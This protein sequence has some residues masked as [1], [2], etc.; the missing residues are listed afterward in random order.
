MRCRR[1]AN[2]NC[3][4]L[5]LLYMSSSLYS[6]HTVDKLCAKEDVGIVEHAVLE[7][8]DNELGVLEVSLE[9]EPDILRV[10]QIQRRVHLVQ[11]V[12]RGWPEQ[13]EAED[14]AESYQ[15][16]LPTRQL[17]QG[18]FPNVAKGHLDLK[19]ALN[20]IHAVRGLQLGL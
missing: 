12:E 18:L 10:R 1:Y 3:F 4:V 11:N 15:R 8:D 14:K 13:Q 5:F 17:G 16:P 20:D 6:G 7:R 19:T 9:H 2:K